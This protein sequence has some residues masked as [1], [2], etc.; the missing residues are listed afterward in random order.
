MLMMKL[1]VSIQQLVSTV[2]V[3]T[4]VYNIYYLLCTLSN[5]HDQERSQTLP[6]GRAQNFFITQGS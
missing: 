3:I 1:M 2:H 6:D 4:R 5:N